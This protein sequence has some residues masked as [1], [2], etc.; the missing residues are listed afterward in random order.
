MG[1][2]RAGIVWLLGFSR[3]PLLRRRAG[4]LA[5]ALLIA[6][7][8]SGVLAIQGGPAVAATARIHLVA[9]AEP[10]RDVLIRLG[11]TAHLNV[12]VGDEVHGAVTLSLSDATP[13]EALHAVCAQARLRCVRDGRT[14]VVSMRSSAVV[15]LTVVPAPRAARVLRGLF[16]HLSVAEGGSGNTLV[17]E[18]T[19]AD[20]QAARA[21]VQGLDVRDPTKASTEALTLRS[22]PAALVADRLRP[23]YPSAKITLVSRSTMLVSAPPGDLAQIKATVA[24]IDAASPQATIAPV[25]SDAVKVLQRRPS[26]I[27][28]GVSSQL[29]HVRVAVSGPT[30]TL[31]GPPE[32]VQRAKALIAQLDVPPF[33]TQYTQIYR[34]KNVDADSVA[35]LIRRAFPQVQVAVDASLN[36][37]SVTASAM[38]Q[39]RIADGIAQLDGTIAPG[40]P[41][42]GGGDEGGPAVIVSTSHEIIQLRSIVPGISGQNSLPSAQD[43]ATAVQQALQPAHPELRVTVP[44]GMQSLILTGSPQSIRDAKELALALDIIPQSVV[45]D[46]EI[47][48]LDENSSRNLGLQLGTNSIGSTF[49]EILPTPS[50][51]GIAGRLI[52]VQPFTR[53]GISF[54]ASVNLLLQNGHARVLADPRITTLSGRTATIRAGDTISILTTV[55]GGTG[56]VATTQLQSFQTGVTLDIT[57]IITNAG[58]LSVALHP[59]VNSLTGYLNGVPQISTR[60]TQTT[61]HLRDNE[62]LVIGG[63]IQENTQRTDSKIPLLGDL[64]LVGR[65]FR[66][67]NTTSTRNELIIVVTPHVLD[68]ANNAIPNAA[69]MPGIGIPTARPLPTLPPNAAFPTPA[70]TPVR[71]YAT[72]APQSTANAKSAVPAGGPTTGPS[73]NAL[74]SAFALANTFVFGSPPPNNF[75]APGDAPQIFYVTLTPTVFTPNSTVRVSAITTTNVQ[76]LT[77]GTGT[78]TITL[79]QVGPGQWQGVFSANVLGL[80]PAATSLRLAL[81]ASRNDGQTASIP[82]TVSI[83]RAPATNDTPL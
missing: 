10:V 12:T 36:A 22:Q 27:A 2:F 7:G 56:T 17:L 58:E 3:A 14:V 60:D 8:A 49:S 68:G 44:N 71:V 48:E 83:L 69:L 47:L 33:G 11:E 28:R 75:A 76:R 54:Q 26:D 30:I 6:L 79:S 19:D 40:Q 5:L 39:Q 16:P 31:S 65:A 74:P 53:T 64:P 59:I 4:S 32:D 77:I 35:G 1:V 62:T 81:V 51:D 38:D 20:I 18:G 72:P 45:L 70:P 50:P 78:S 66:N 25:T 63:L 52:G 67:V 55:G 73:P 82:V 34:L 43:L 9:R 42:G 37:I 13:D 23:L 41:R 80:P 57:P 46:T 21:V 15:P 61:V 24:G 29:T